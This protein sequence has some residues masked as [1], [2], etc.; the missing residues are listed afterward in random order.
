MDC[1]H[2]KLMLSS[3]LDECLV[4][5]ERRT[6]AAHLA[7]CGGC[8]QHLGQLEL[9]RQSL[10]AAP[11]RPMPIHLIYSLRSLASR[12]ATRRRYYTGFR[13]VVRAL[14]EHAALFAANLMRPFALPAAGGILSAVFLFCMVMTNFQGIIREH[15]NDVPLALATEPSVRSIPFDLAGDSEFTVDVLIDE[16]GRVID[17]S[18]PDGFGS[19]ST[20]SLRRYLESA[21][22][23]TEFNPGTTF[24][25]PVSGWVKVKFTGRSQIDVRG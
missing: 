3:L 25:Q 5:S 21:L 16:Q 24:G 11:R 13:G 2:V 9:V 12:E 22:L 7:R 10:R 18:F 15:P 6:I 19:L 17:Y 20:A 8:S 1:Q 23:L 4:D 14:G